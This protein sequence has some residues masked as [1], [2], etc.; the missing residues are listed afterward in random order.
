LGVTLDAKLARP[1]IFGLCDGSLS[2]LGVVLY[3]SGHGT[4]V[5]PIAASGGLS[6]AVS[7]AGGEWLSASSDGPAAAVMMGLATLAGS[8]IPALPYLFLRGWAA[9]AVAVVLLAAVAYVV[10]RLRSHR[11]HPYLETAAVLGAVLAVSVA[12]ALLMPGGTG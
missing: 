1:M 12:C 8:I 3:A 4:L 9:P 10:A 5:F 7:M 6:A 11:E 2:I